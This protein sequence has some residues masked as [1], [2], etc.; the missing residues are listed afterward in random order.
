MRNYYIIKG[1]FF[2]FFLLMFSDQTCGQVN[3]NIIGSWINTE[4][5]SFNERLEPDTRKVAESYLKYN[6]INNSKVDITTNY[7]SNARYQNYSIKKNI[8]RIENN[9]SLLIEKID[10]ESM[11]L[12]E[13]ENEIITANSIRYHFAKEQIYLD[14][15][16]LA[17][18]DIIVNSHDTIYMES[19]KLFPQ[20]KNKNFPDF[21]LYVQSYVKDSY[22]GGELYCHASFNIHPNGKISEINIL[23][24]VSETYDARLAKA[25]K[26]SE[27]MWSIPKLN[28]KEV[29]IVKVYDDRDIMPRKTS[30]FDFTPLTFKKYTSEYIKKFNTLART[31]L[32][33]N[34][35]KALEYISECEKIIGRENNLL[36]LKYL[37]YD[38]SG[39]NKMAEVYLDLVQKSDLKYL[40]K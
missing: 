6:F 7:Q 37:S 34:Y 27:G 24:H 17:S 4:T 10:S 33:K 31:L 1:A 3:K 29:I 30:L 32:A 2:T 11:V 26:E 22:S 36:F 35:L 5:E 21:H 18:E 39:N 38:K 14:R 28:G 19:K 40:I 15:L 16:P 23:H 20:F 8:L 13:L 25:I 9:R 12:V